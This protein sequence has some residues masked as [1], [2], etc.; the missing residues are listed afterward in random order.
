MRRSALLLRVILSSLPTFVSAHMEMSWPYPIRSQLDPSVAEADK[1]YSYTSPLLQNGSD[2]P[3]K[4]YQ[5]GVD[6]D[7]IKEVYTAGG[8]YNMSLAG[9]VTHDGGSCQL[10]LSYDNGLT[11]KV[12]Q[13]MIG[14]KCSSSYEMHRINRFYQRELILV[15]RMSP[16]SLIQ[17]HNSE[18]RTTI[19]I[20]SVRVV[21]VQS[22]WGQRNVHELR[23]C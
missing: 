16:K 1:D 3:C 21:L 15:Y 17:L 8:T 6:S 10:S 11:F 22:G 23:S 14:G 4:G 7:I 5:N 20:S 9:T 12:I 18:L 13:S 19:S 2:F